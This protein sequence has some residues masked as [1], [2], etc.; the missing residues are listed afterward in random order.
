MTRGNARS[1][2]LFNRIIGAAIMRGRLWIAMIQGLC[3]VMFPCSIEKAARVLFAKAS[4]A[5]N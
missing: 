5:N 3:L 1:G 2:R 4:S